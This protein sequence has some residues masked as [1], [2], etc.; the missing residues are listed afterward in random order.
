[1]PTHEFTH[2]HHRAPHQLATNGKVNN[3]QAQTNGYSAL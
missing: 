2:T 3:S 1:M